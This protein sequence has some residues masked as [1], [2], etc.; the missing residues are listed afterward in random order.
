MPYSCAIVEQSAEPVLS[1]RTRTPLKDL[2]QALQRAYGGIIQYLGEL[3]EA[4]AGPPFVAYYNMNMDD[5]DVEIGFPVARELPGRGDVEASEIPAGKYATT[6]YT[7]PYKGIGSAYDALAQWMQ[8]NDYE[9]T[10]VAYE[11]Y[12]NDPQTVAPGELETRILMPLRGR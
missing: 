6:D 7:G 8:Q 10:G 3:D 11:L 2:P 12:L 5:L 1:V 4:P 9:P